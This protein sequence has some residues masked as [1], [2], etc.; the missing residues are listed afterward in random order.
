MNLKLMFLLLAMCLPHVAFSSPVTVATGPFNISFDID[1]TKTLIYQPQFSDTRKGPGGEA[2]IFSGLSIKDSNTPGDAA[3][4]Q[5]SINEYSSPIS[6]SLES[7]AEQAAK[8]FQILDETV[9][10]DYRT[11]DNCPGYAVKGVNKSGRIEYSS[12]YRIGNETEVMIIGALPEISSIL[13]TIHIERRS[14]P[15]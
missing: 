6:Y 13:D 14:M 10:I 9:S 8:L 11:I 3:K 1:T 4:A 12:G 15:T 2:I 5:I 7:K